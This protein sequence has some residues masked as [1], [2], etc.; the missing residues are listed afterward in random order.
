MH[1][2]KKSTV[3]EARIIT[4]LTTTVGI[5]STLDYERALTLQLYSNASRTKTAYRLRRKPMNNDT[6]QGK[7]KQLR[8]NIKAAFGKLTDDDL[9]QA[10]GNADKMQGSLQERYGYTKE[11]AQTEWDKFAR[12]YA[13]TVDDAKADLNAAA[14]NIKAAAGHIK[15]AA[16]R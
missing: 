15:D 12:E 2:G 11:K 5:G 8:G 9:L 4:L 14:A 7:W 16:Q 10:D 6:F 1:N 3:V 13:D